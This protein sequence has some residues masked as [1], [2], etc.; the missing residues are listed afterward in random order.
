VLVAL[1]VA[2]SFALL[3]GAA[4]F[5]RSLG[6]V[7]AIEG[8]A[9]LD[10]LLTVEVN[11]AEEDGDDPSRPYEAF[12]ERALDRL[13]AMPVVERAAVVDTPPYSGWARSVFWRMPGDEEY[14]SAYMNIAGP[15]YFETAG[16]RL[17]RGRAILASDTAGAE[18]IGVVNEA[19]ARRLGSDG[20][21]LG[22]CVPFE[23]SRLEVNTCYHIV[24]VVESQRHD[25]LDPEP[26]PL[27][28][29]AAAQAPSALPRDAWM[30]LVR[31]DGDAADHR[32]AVQSALQRLRPDL[33]HVRVAPLAERL[34]PQL[35]PF[36][37]GA[38][39]FSFVRRAGPGPFGYRTA[40][41]AGILRRRADGRGRD[42][43]GT[44][45]AWP[46][47][48]AARGAAVD[49]AGGHRDGDRPGSRAGRRTHPGVAVVRHRPARPPVVCRR[50][51]LPHRRGRRRHGDP[52]LAGR[53]D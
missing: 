35:R 44:R 37:L 32:V 8:G 1:Q 50:R 53:E 27:V 42:P 31:T 16:T 3:V 28:F 11:L 6:Q 36:R 14:Q 45:I 5:V 15:G 22:M 39:L 12:F 41:C 13:D 48:R 47:G 29:L 21:V 46:R 52:R 30:L 51:G 49:G 17:L 33:P 34:Q 26:V 25:Y 4:L 24:G 7:S 19:M 20:D 38:M 9:D 23:G 40:R 43:A 2:L 18:A 10:R